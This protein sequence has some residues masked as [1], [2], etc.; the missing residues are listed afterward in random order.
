LQ[1]DD[2]FAVEDTGLHPHP[3]QDSLE[4]PPAMPP[5]TQ[6]KQQ[7]ASRWRALDNGILSALP[8]QTTQ[9]AQAV[10]SEAVPYTRTR[11]RIS[12]NTPEA[13]PHEQTKLVE[14]GFFGERKRPVLADF[15]RDWEEKEDLRI[16]QDEHIYAALDIP[17]KRS[18]ST[19]QSK[20]LGPVPEAPY[21]PMLRSA[22][23][24]E[25]RRRELAKA[26]LASQLEK[27][28]A[29]GSDKTRW[30]SSVEMSS[31]FST[32]AEGLNEG[33]GMRESARQWWEE[34]NQRRSSEFGGIS[35]SSLS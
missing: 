31:S 2:P 21:H 24:R 7:S 25:M 19:E 4:N 6:S 1:S 11:K 8:L 34:I 26:R 35:S 10:T 5:P 13:D 18:D 12:G 30:T 22:G 16:E 20:V 3:G 33:V 27:E 32:D 23:I 9:P 29:D 14:F 28:K 15:E 17:A